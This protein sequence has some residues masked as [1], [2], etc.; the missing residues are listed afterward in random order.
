MNQRE[1]LLGGIR[2]TQP[3]YTFG[4]ITSAIDA[5]GADV[6]A[7][8]ADEQRTELD[9]KLLVAAAYIGVL[10]AQRLLEVADDGIGFAR[11]QLDAVESVGLRRTPG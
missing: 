9:V 3:L 8:V 1:F 7:A 11:Q 10:Q 5:A 4:R 2:A 6:T